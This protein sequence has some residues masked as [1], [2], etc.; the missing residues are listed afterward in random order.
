MGVGTD[1]YPFQER[2]YKSLPHTLHSHKTIQVKE[3]NVILEK[4]PGKYFYTLGVGG[5]LR[6]NTKQKL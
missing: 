5:Y 4:S 3:F 6:Y 2:T 1:S